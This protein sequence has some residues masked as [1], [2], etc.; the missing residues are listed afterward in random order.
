MNCLI[1]YTLSRYKGKEVSAEVISR[2]LRIKHK[3]K[4]DAQVLLRRIQTEGYTVSGL[5]MFSDS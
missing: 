5:K 3:I 1:N 2:Y 4:M